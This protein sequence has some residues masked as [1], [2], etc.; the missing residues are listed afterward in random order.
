MIGASRKFA[1]ALALGCCAAVGAAQSIPP[2]GDAAWASE[3]DRKRAAV[4]EAREADWRIGAVVYQVIVDRFAPPENLEA[5]RALYPE[6]KKLRAWSETPTR[7]TRLESVKV[8]SHELDFWGGDLQSLRTKLSYIHDLGVDVLY[9]NPI[10]LAYTNHKYDSQDYFKVSPE[11]GTREDVKALAESLHG[12]NMKLVLDGVFNHMGRTSPHFQEALANP[13]SEYRNWYYIDPQFKTHGYRA[14]YDV[15]NL[16]EV[17]LENPEVRNQLFLGPDSVVQGYLRDGVDGWRL[18]VAFDIGFNYLSELTQAAHKTKPGSLVV[19]EIWNYPEEWTP[20]V[21]GV[22]NFHARQIILNL[23]NE[24]ISGEY[25]GRLLDQMVQDAGLEPIMRSWILLDNHDTKRLATE[26]NEDWKRHMA[27]TIQFTIPGSPNLYYGAELG[28]QGGDDPECRAPMRWDL[29]N[30]NNPE[31]VWMKKL[32][33]LRATNRALRVGDFRLLPSQRLLAFMRS[34]DHVAETVIVLANP[35]NAEV[36]DLVGIRNSKLMN[37]VRMQD[38]FSDTQI[39]IFAGLADVTV[40]AHTILV[41]KPL[42][43]QEGL[44]YTPYKRVQ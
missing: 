15:A 17:N 4:F 38:Q 43:A 12:M 11:Y 23:V 41:L 35:T 1:L 5:K 8:E 20:A 30:D 39:T 34:T 36:K 14:W 21:D 2:S 6:P 42:I 16:P 26:I 32:M 7:G 40:P 10:Q 28:M 24:K 13:G 18:D 44:E 33:H 27:R 31:F 9:L 19:G 29:A 3:R 22:M 37:N 25:A